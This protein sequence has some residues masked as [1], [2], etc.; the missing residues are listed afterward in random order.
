M[1]KK[2][3]LLNQVTGPLFIDIANEYAKKY[4]EVILI[5]G[6]LEPTYVDLD[7]KVKVIYKIAYKRNKSYLRILTWLIF[8]LQTYMYFFLKRNISEVLIVTNPP[9]LPFLGGNFFSKRKINFSLL[10]YDVYP[11]ALYNFGYIKETSFLYKY[12]DKISKKAYANAT[13]LIT[14]SSVMKKVVSRNINEDKVKVIYPWVDIS[15]IK[16]LQK[17][18]NWFVEKNKLVAKK[19]ILYSGN[20]GATHD[21]ITPL[22][23]AKDISKTH[24]SFHF[25]FIGDGVQKKS[26]IDYVEQYKLKNVTFLPYQDSEVLP[27]SFAAADFS[28]VSLGTGAEGLS[29]PSKTFYSLAAGSAIIAISEKGSEIEQLI[30]KN[31]CGISIEP[32]DVSLMKEFLINTSELDLEN[33]KKNSRSLSKQFTVN[34]VKYFVK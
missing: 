21:L 17:E 12:W 1:S 26:L 33:K 22:K 4:D 32:N 9:I 23:V 34:N 8:Y 31:N 19:V 5:T 27:F 3:T 30:S 24:K 16:P 18:E 28:I 13:E 11:D 14:I 25:L 20:M 2:I 7:K 15:F 29:V 6:A 10:I